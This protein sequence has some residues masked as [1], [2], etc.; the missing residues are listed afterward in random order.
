MFQKMAQT[1][2]YRDLNLCFSMCVTGILLGKL[3]CYPLRHILPHDN[4]VDGLMKAM[5]MMV[6]ATAAAIGITT[7]QKKSYESIR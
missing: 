2:P 3:M 4:D 1:S 6:T 7:K 5:K